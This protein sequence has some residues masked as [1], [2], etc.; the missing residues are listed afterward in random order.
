MKLPKPVR[1][2]AEQ[3]EKLP[4]IGPKSAQRHAFYLLR[5]PEYV[6]D[7]FAQSLRDLKRLTKFCEFCHN[8]GESSPCI[9]CED[10]ER[11]QASLCVV[12][13]PLDVLALEQS[14][15]F[16]GRY[17]VLHGVISPLDNIGPDELYLRD[18][19][20]RLE[21]ISEVIL[22]TNPTMEGEG[23]ALF[24]EKMI[25]EAGYSSDEIRVTRIGHGLPVGA[26]IEFADS[27]TLSRALEGRRTL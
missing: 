23:T 12:E 18:I 10:S 14:G 26:D 3:F 27:V 11:D 2:V 21:G 6:L 13:S 9:I 24:I 25:R 16:T 20:K 5:V 7:E 22:A 1:A 4:G 19:L 8:I 17:H 15:K